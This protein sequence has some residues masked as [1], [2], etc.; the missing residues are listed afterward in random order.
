MYLYSVFYRTKYNTSSKHKHTRY[1]YYHFSVGIF[2]FATCTT[3]MRA[4]IWSVVVVA[5]IV[6]NMYGYLFVYKYAVYTY[7]QQI[8]SAYVQCTE[9]YN[10]YATYSVSVYAGMCTL[11]NNIIRSANNP[12][13]FSVNR[14][15]AV[16]T[17]HSSRRQT[18]PVRLISSISIHPHTKIVQMQTNIKYVYITTILY[19]IRNNFV[20]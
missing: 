4:T 13:S 5:V 15:R 2:C 1:K 17:I 16:A 7:R 3:C 9:T 11:S 6:M 10:I 8:Q 20:L 12:D 19:T 14:L 18:V